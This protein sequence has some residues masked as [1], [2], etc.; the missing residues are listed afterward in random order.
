M[1]AVAVE[2]S[3]VRLVDQRVALY[4]PHQVGDRHFPL[5][6]RDGSLRERSYCRRRP[7]PDRLMTKVRAPAQRY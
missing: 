5:S 6:A 2:G 1:L 3:D 7:L 4:E